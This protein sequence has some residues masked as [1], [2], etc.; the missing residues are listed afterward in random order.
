[1]AGFSKLVHVWQFK[2]W[3]VQTIFWGQGTMPQ[4]SVS[5]Q[6]HSLKNYQLDSSV[7]LKQ[8]SI[9]KPIIEVQ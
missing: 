2:K 9:A 4:G 5:K 7:N 8:S 6:I 1:M 3:K